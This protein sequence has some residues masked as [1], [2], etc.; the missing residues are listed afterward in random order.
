M[1]F[2][3]KLNKTLRKILYDEK[4]LNKNDDTDLKKDEDITRRREEGSPKNNEDRK[5]PMS[6]IDSQVPQS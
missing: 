2:L 3:Q 4:D 1:K 5:K 6:N